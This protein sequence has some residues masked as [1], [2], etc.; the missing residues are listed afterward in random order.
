VIA[1]GR[2]GALETV[3]GLEHNVEAPCRSG[4]DATHDALQPTGVFFHEPSPEGLMAAIER[5]ESQDF[6]VEA[7][8]ASAARFGSERFKREMTSQVH[9]LLGRGQA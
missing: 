5:F 2:G 4:E 8:Q 6:S 7:L 9:E 3:I 1:Y